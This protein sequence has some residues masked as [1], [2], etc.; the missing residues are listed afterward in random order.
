MRWYTD[1]ETP[2]KLELAGRLGTLLEA[3]WEHQDG[4]ETKLD[5]AYRALTAFLL[6]IRLLE[7]WGPEFLDAEA[8]CP[9]TGKLE[10]LDWG[11]MCMHLEA[12]EQWMGEN[13]KFPALQRL[14]K[15]F[16]GFYNGDEDRP[17]HAVRVGLHRE[18]AGAIRLAAQF[19]MGD[20]F[21]KLRATCLREAARA[22]DWLTL[23]LASLDSWWSGSAPFG[24][25]ERSTVMATVLATPYQKTPLERLVMS[26]QLTN[27]NWD[28][29]SD[30]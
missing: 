8:L 23:G 7:E 22:G 19:Q 18:A 15:S 6:G 10:G 12:L 11:A 1:T 16:R 30:G 27:L 9:V 26:G 20:F 29:I 25:P 2:G 3:F 14:Y 5:P 24:P 13:P 4:I 21:P 28:G 17:S